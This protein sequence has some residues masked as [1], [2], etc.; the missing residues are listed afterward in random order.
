ML[1]KLLKYELKSTGRIFLPF[2]IAILV[3]S[4]INKITIMVFSS[5][6]YF[7]L[8]QAL[9]IFLYVA[10]IIAAFVMTLIV[11]VQ[12]FYKNLLGSE[13]Y[14]MFTVPV[15]TTQNILAKAITAFLWILSTILVT[16]V[17]V[18]IVIPEYGWIN[19]LPRIIGQVFAEMENFGFQPAVCVTLFIAAVLLSCIAFIMEI[20]AA[21][22]I[23]QLSNTHKLLASFGAYMGI[24]MVNQAL[25]MIAISI[26]A[27]Q[28]YAMPAPAAIPTPT[29]IY[30]LFGFMIG[31]MVVMTVACF[32]V[33]RYLLGK[34]LNLE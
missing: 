29:F 34:K 26:V 8:P 24:Y 16:L 3:L 25:G 18:L 31:E 1:G 11:T 9:L 10:F 19:E 27:P 15:T 21:I 22:S 20:Y 33:S 17:S 13:G 30:S 4:I 28:I 12:R 6:Q 7:Q 14:L 2:Y 32:F 23:G 5:V